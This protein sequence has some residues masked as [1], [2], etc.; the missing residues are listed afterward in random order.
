MLAGASQGLSHQEPT[1]PLEGSR[2]E[3]DCRLSDSDI[4]TLNQ[5]QVHAST[6]TPAGTTGDDGSSIKAPVA[7]PDDIEK[8]ERNVEKAME[9]SGIED[10]TRPELTK[11]RAIGLASTMV[12]ISDASR[13]TG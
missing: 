5:S 2:I 11:A 9:E 3:Q 7:V 6:M 1:N 8:E 4:A 13:T 10:A 12:S